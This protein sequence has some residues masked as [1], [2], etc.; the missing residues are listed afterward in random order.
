M[1]EHIFT[2]LLDDLVWVILQI[3]IESD[4]NRANH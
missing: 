3:D 4:L 2:K 1:G